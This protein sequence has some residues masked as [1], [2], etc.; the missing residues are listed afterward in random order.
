MMAYRQPMRDR[1]KPRAKRPLLVVAIQTLKGADECLLKQ[2]FRIGGGADLALEKA[3]QPYLKTSGELAERVAAP[4][5][6]PPGE[7]LVTLS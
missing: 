2:I 6:G 7:L 5:P 3:K 4:T 1:V